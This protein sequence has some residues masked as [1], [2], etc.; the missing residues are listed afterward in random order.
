M[1]SIRES[2]SRMFFPTETAV[3]QERRERSVTTILY[4]MN[5]STVL[6]Y[7]MSEMNRLDVVHKDGHETLY[8]V[9]ESLPTN[10]NATLWFVCLKSPCGGIICGGYVVDTIPDCLADPPLFYQ[11]SRLGL[12]CVSPS[13]SFGREFL[14]PVSIKLPTYL[15]TV[16]QVFAV[17][18]QSRPN[19]RKNVS[20]KKVY[21]FKTSVTVE[22][23]T[24]RSSSIH[25]S[26][27]KNLCE[28]N[29]KSSSTRMISYNSEICSIWPTKLKCLVLLRN[30]TIQDG[31]QCVGRIYSNASFTGKAILVKTEDFTLVMDEKGL[32]TTMYVMRRN[33]SIFPMNLT[34]LAFSPEN[35][36]TL[37]PF[38][39]R[40]LEDEETDDIQIQSST[41]E[42]IGAKSY[43]LKHAI[44][45]IM[46]FSL[47]LPTSSPETI[48]NVIYFACF[49]FFP[50]TEDKAKQTHVE[51]LNL[52]VDCFECALEMGSELIAQSMRANI[53]HLVDRVEY[54][55]AEKLAKMDLALKEYMFPILAKSPAFETKTIHD[56]GLLKEMIIGY[57]L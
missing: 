23:A 57:C 27:G 6:I 31:K 45:N 35:N 33:A 39:K 42:Q 38:I 13:I 4:G 25:Y 41:G 56:H 40:L 26:I 55:I 8:P 21:D 34:T 11:H 14:L 7:N 30:G 50:W 18:D 47:S 51:K 29:I 28:T 19:Q 15:D 17:I 52:F 1:A 48:R 12:L 37:D 44:P 49:G 32:T 2:T 43:L 3:I 9:P 20:H 53:I 5:E 24:V 54:P 46:D 22:N 36:L 10:T 16:N